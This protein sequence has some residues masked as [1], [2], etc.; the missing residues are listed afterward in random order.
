VRDD[1]RVAD[2]MTRPTYRVIV[3]REGD[4]WQARAHTATMARR[5]IERGMSVRDAATLLG[6]LSTCFPTD[7]A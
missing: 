4:A 6:E 1:L 5:L 7:R 3:T 2:P